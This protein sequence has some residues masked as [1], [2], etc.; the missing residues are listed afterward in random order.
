MSLQNLTLPEVQSFAQK[1][2]FFRE[3]TT[4]FIEIQFVGSKDSIVK[5]VAPEHMAKFREEWNAY[6]DGRPPQRRQGTDLT[7]IGIPAEKAE[8]YAFRN[9]HTL[10]EL[11]ALSDAQCQGLG[12]GTLTHRQMAQKLLSAHAMEKAAAAR[13]AVSEGAATLSTE[14]AAKVEQSSGDIAELKTQVGDL[15][16]AVAA[17]VAAMQPVEV[18]RGPGRPKKVEPAPEPAA[19]PEEG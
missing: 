16:K 4:D 11:A 12:H 18:K 9:V 7:A 13:D 14:V 10:E 3:G 2:R 17:L 19:E 5:K 6:C 15:T 1:G 8:E